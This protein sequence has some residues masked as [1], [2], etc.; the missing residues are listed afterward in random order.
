MKKISFLNKENKI[1]GKRYRFHKKSCNKLL[2]LI[3]LY[4]SFFKSFLDT[5]TIVFLINS[6]DIPM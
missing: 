6:A 3:I 4:S 5:F 1:Q 2:F